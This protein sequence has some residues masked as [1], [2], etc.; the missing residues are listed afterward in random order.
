MPPHVPARIAIML[1][2]FS[3]YGGVEQFGYRLS[4]A[5]ASRGHFVDFICA[6]QE[7]DPPKG[8]R[9]R[10][11]GR[12]HGPRW[13]K[14][15]T[16]AG[17][18]EAF[19]RAGDYDCAV[20]LGKTRSQD[21]LRVGGGP[22]P[23][24]RRYSEKAYPNELRRRVK[25]FTRRISPANLLTRWLE[26][27]QYS[28]TQYIV[29]VS[30]FVRDLVL[31]AAPA[32]DPARVRII[33]NR[34]DLRRYAPPSVEQRERARRRFGMAPEVTAIGL[35]T[36][37]FLLKGV[38]PLI[39]AL[40][41]LPGNCAL[42]VAGGRNHGDYDAL[43]HRLGVADRVHFLGTVDDMPA[44]YQAIDVF[45]LPSFYDACSNAVL[46]ALATGTPTLSSAAN[47]SSHFLPPEN[48]VRDPGDSEELAGVLSRLVSEA[49]G[50]K[51]TG[52]RK[53]FAWPEDVVAGLDAFV[54]V[55]EEFLAAR[56]SSL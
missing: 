30:H 38:A 37:N 1:P 9:I 24:I 45:A 13:L 7:I 23:A 16:F 2:R 40:L 4:E 43:A 17:K 39:R 15:L 35:A 44:W 55:V 42:Y 3:R 54:D 33:Y 25:Q 5:L 48:I 47:G 12:P 27:R 53:P 28:R 22:L 34:P 21:S 51:K 10:R 26:N 29:A 56:A 41:R 36:S 14:M 6:R 46:E 49:E 18:A 31:E 8:V 20:S 52:A 19:R 50:N 11:T 32:I